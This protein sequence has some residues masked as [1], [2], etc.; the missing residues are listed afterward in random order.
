MTTDTTDELVDRL[1]AILDRERQALTGGM[2]DM[3]TD[4]MAE[5]DQVIDQITAFESIGQDRLTPLRDKVHRNQALLD[6]ALAGIRAVATRMAELRKVREG[7]ETYDS[8]G[9]KT[10]FGTTASSSIEKRA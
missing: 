3:L 5:K 7:L 8:A 2:L 9:R 1:D 6:N 10:R 4:L